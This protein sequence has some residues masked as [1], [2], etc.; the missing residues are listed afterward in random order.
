MPRPR[1]EAKRW[2][3]MLW[4]TPEVRAEVEEHARGRGESVAGMLLRLAREDM[5]ASPQKPNPETD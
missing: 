1:G 4:A 2:S 5:A 3:V